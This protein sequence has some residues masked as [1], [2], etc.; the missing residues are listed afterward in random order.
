M[1]SKSDEYLVKAHEAEK[2]AIVTSDPDLRRAFED[3]A[4]EWFRMAEQATRH[5][6]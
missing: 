2:R 1:A 6:W 5:G 3:I 4:K